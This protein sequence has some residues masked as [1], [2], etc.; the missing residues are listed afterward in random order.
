MYHACVTTLCLEGKPIEKNEV[1]RCQYENENKLQ[2]Q[3]FDILSRIISRE[4]YKGKA[5]D[6]TTL[7]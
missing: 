7:S 2:C 4:D 6:V 5:I 1:H 3:F